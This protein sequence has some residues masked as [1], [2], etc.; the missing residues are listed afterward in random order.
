MTA[1]TTTMRDPDGRST[2]RA[3]SVMP[4]SI[5]PTKE[6]IPLTKRAPTTAPSRLVEP[7]MTSIASVMNVRS[8][9]TVS[10]FSGSRCT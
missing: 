2:V 6:S 9:Y 8:R 4:S 3:K 10:L 7:P 5:S 1:L